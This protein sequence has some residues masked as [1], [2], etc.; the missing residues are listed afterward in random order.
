MKYL[1]KALFVFVVGCC[2]N[3]VFGRGSKG[4]NTT[5]QMRN[6]SLSVPFGNCSVARRTRTDCCIFDIN[7]PNSSNSIGGLG[8]L[9][10]NANGTCAFNKMVLST[11]SNLNNCWHGSLTLKSKNSNWSNTIDLANRSQI[12][13]LGESN[14]TVNVPAGENIEAILSVLEPCMPFDCRMRP[15]EFPRILWYSEGVLKPGQPEPF[16]MLLGETNTS[17]VGMCN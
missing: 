16:D 8:Q 5:P 9:I 3:V 2:I 4:S 12:S 14:I 17:T 15:Q 1:K 13:V 6:V 11:A 10:Q 7:N